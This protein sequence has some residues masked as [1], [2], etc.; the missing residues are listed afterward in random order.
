MTKFFRKLVEREVGYLAGFLYRKFRP[1]VIGV[2]GSSGKTTT[3]YMIGELLS[4]VKSNILVSSGNLNTEIG[5]PLAMIGYQGAPEKFWGW[6]WVFLSA[7]VKTFFRLKYPPYLVLEYA[8]DRPRDIE[9]LTSIVPPDIAVI[10]NIGVAH[11]AAFKKFENIIREKWILAQS[12]QQFVVCDNSVLKKVEALKEPKAKIVETGIAE[13]VKIQNEEKLTNGT[14]FELILRGKKYNCRTKFMGRHNLGN[15][16]LALIAAHLATGERDE[17]VKK[18]ETLEPLE[19]RGRKFIGE[20][21]IVVIDE[22]YNANPLSMLAAIEVFSSIKA[23][24]KV[25][26]LGEMCE[27]GEITAASHREIAKRVKSI[28]TLTVGVGESFKECGLD[29]WYPSVEELKA[30]IK[31]ILQKGDTVLIKGSLSNRLKEIV[32]ILK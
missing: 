24:R 20:N 21:E 6:I 12:A 27:I 4:T 28:A 23:G 31:Q 11:L 2:T 3:K 32:E 13:N 9:Y 22:S 15:L 8:A 18:I 19:G 10:V 14:E 25:A 7:P 5:L 1:Y 29:K 26:I 17:L 30:D 16:E